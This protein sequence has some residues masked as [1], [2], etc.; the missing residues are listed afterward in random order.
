MLILRARKVEL[1][2]L[3]KWS[4]D[5]NRI[6]CVVTSDVSLFTRCHWGEIQRIRKYQVI[7]NRIVSPIFENFW[8][9][10][11][12][13]RWGRCWRISNT[14]TDVTPWCHVTFWP[15][16]SNVIFEGKTGQLCALVKST[17]FIVGHSNFEMCTSNVIFWYYVE[18]I[19]TS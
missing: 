18:K 12:E 15:R 17:I 5:W 6:Y 7:L 8:R 11:Y 14:Q 1:F 10:Y 3:Q 4:G 13:G 19:F 16:E 9:R 2:Y